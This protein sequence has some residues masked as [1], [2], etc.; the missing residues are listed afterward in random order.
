MAVVNRRLLGVAFLLVPVLLIALSVAVYQKKFSTVTSV[1]LHTSTAGYEM[2]QGADVKVHGV[3]V[4]E[5]R[6]LTADGNGVTMKLALKPSQA[7]SIP[8]DV[9]AQ[10]LPTTV[11]GARYVALIPPPGSGL[12]DPASPAAQPLRDGSEITQNNSAN[13]IEL[14]VVLNNTM[15]LL[16]SIRPA[17]LSATLNAMAQALQGRGERLGKNLVLLGEYLKKLNPELPALTRNLSELVEFTR[18]YSEAVPDILQA[19]TDFT[20]T[21][22]TIVDQR[23][24]LSDLYRTGIVA[25]QDARD[26]FDRNGINIIE[27]AATSRPTLET[28]ARYSPEFPCLF[29]LLADFVPKMDKVLGKGTKEPG[30]HI[31]LHSLKSKGPYKPGKD[32]PAYKTDRGPRCYPVPYVP[33]AGKVPPATGPRA[34][35]PVAVVPGGLGIPNSAGENQLV[36]ELVAAGVQEVPG[37]LPDW[38]STLLGP[39]YRGNRVTVDVPAG[40]GR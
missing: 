12:I 7:R 11:F 17:E 15:R 33:G 35:V 8:A 20:T 34:A 30:M 38:T 27:L 25:V 4:G 31:T 21:S 9:Q 39:L 6:S 5:V 14:S 22:R 26:F 36:N 16:N 13:A 19:L 37:A 40:G 3:V 10:L 28:L 18:N 24:T 2:H 23:G 29:G 1:T 32:T